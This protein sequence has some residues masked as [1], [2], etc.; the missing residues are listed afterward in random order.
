M[1]ACADRCGAVVRVG[2]VGV[3]VDFFEKSGERRELVHGFKCACLCH[4]G[5]FGGDG[6]GRAHFFS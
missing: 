2:L 1:V 6:T 5:G 3:E 4:V